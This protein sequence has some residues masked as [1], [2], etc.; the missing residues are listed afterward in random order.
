MVMGHRG[1]GTSSLI[2]MICDK[3]KLDELVLKQTYF[4]KL[5]EEKELRKRRRLLDR[6]FRPP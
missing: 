1:A 6:G 2:R 3:Y 5:K 4:A